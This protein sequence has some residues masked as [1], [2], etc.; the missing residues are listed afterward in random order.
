M[1]LSRLALILAAWPALA[2]ANAPGA[3]LPQVAPGQPQTVQTGQFVRPSVGAAPAWVDVAP[4]PKAPSDADGAATID[5]LGD[6]QVRFSKVDETTY[7]GMAW[8]IGTA[9]GL[10]S[11]TLKVDWDPSLEVLTIHRY[12]VLR[13]GKPIDF[14][15]D[16]SGIKVIQR[17]TGMESAMLDGRLTATM[18][19]EDLRVGDV[20]E[21]SYS[22]VR[23][24]PAMQGFSSYMAGPADGATFGRF[25]IRM[26]WDK[27]KQMQWRAWPGVLQPRLKKTPQGSELVADVVDKTTPRAP[28]NAPRRFTMVNA[29]EVTEFKDWPAVSS[30]FAPLYAKAATL[31]PDSPIKAEAARIAAQT[32]DPKR[33]AELALA[34][35]QNQVRYLFLGMDAGGFVPA[36]ADQTWARR[37]GDC[38]GKTVLL[39]ALLNDLGIEARPVLVHTK[40]GDLVGTRLPSMDAFDHVLVEAKIGGKSYWL[41]GTRLGDERLDRL[42]V[43]SY[44]FGLPVSAKGTG[45]VAL[46]PEP[47]A[48]PATTVT[49]SID[50]S[51]GLDLPAPASAEM[52]FSG[53]YA[54]EARQKFAGFSQAERNRELRKVWRE[55]FDTITPNKVAT[56]TDPETGDF[57]MT[58]T[59]LAQMEWTSD[60]GTRWYEVDR[61]R[62]GW[63]FNIAREGDLNLDAPFAFDYPDWWSSKVTIILPHDGRGF[64]LQGSDPVDRTVGDLYHFRRSVSLKDGRVVME[65]DTRALAAELPAARAPRTRTELVEL[66]GVGVYIRAPSDYEP[67]SAEQDQIRKS[68]EAESQAKAKAKAKAK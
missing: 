58:M 4:L 54:S 66:A 46:V 38:K 55:S 36:D 20:V 45:L 43:P 68:D 22:V 11:G 31:A 57:V 13:D 53:P 3:V 27:D 41:D 17:E 60:L 24:D 50:A 15:R 1:R 47:L 14:L 52:R 6:V 42:Q 19:P 40:D 44:H 25:R 65:A 26:L 37:F 59:G 39:I 5:L 62:L 23:K 34:L 29:V 61:S 16:G 30:L 32:S 8:I 28:E 48:R 49:L 9:E 35:V 21:L 51:Q 10:D 33:R 12:R 63:R 64:R 56:R 18:Q 67:T 7:Y 2:L